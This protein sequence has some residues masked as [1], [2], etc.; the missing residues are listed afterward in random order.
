MKTPMNLALKD[1]NATWRGDNANL[2]HKC[3]NGKI[4]HT[5]FRLAP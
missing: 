3:Q 2:V 1:L 4:A 5:H